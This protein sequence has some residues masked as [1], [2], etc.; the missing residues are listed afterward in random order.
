M[1]VPTLDPTAGERARKMR[2]DPG[3]EHRVTDPTDPRYG[4]PPLRT[5]ELG[6]RVGRVVADPTETRELGGRVGRVVDP[7][8]PECG[9]RSD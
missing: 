9:T 3:A 4:T 5:R 2:Q 1:R 7:T 8:D 6:G